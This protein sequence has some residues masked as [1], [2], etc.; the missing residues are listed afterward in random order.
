MRRLLPPAVVVISAVMLPAC[1][2]LPVTYHASP[3]HPGEAPIPE[4]SLQRI[5]AERLNRAQVQ[6]L[7]GE[8][9]ASI[10]GDTSAIAYSRC[11]I[12]SGKTIGV[13]LMIPV[14][15][16]GDWSD[17]SCQVVG[18]WFDVEGYAATVKAEWGR[19]EEYGQVCALRPWLEGGT[20]RACH[21]DDTYGPERN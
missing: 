20:V 7:L 9:D 17:S 18:V 14:P 15:I 4:E 12:Q 2:E 1:G 8:P 11:E 21:P 3:L 16:V 6:S 13:V 10:E 19:Y 5:K